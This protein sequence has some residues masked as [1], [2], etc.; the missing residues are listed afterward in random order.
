MN[1][2]LRHFLWTFALILSIFVM[3]GSTVQAEKEK[4][5]KYGDFEYQYIK[6]TEY[7]AIVGY[8]GR[9]EIIIYPDKIEGK[10]VYSIS[11]IS[12]YSCDYLCDEFW[13]VKEV[14][15]PEGVVELEDLNAIRNLEKVQLPKTLEI[16]GIHAFE[17]CTKLESIELPEGLKK[18]ERDAFCDCNSLKEIHIPKGVALI[19]DLAFAGCSGLQKVS[20]SP[21]VKMI[22]VEAF[23]DCTSLREII[24][25]DTV[26][27]IEDGAFWGCKKLTK[28]KLSKN[29]TT[30]NED[31][32]SECNIKTIEIPKKVKKIEAGAFMENAFTSVVIPSKVTY[33]GSNA[34]AYCK[35]LKKVTIKGT[36]LKQMKNRAFANINKKATFDVPNKCKKKYKKMLIKA[37]SF[38][39]GKMK[40]K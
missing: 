2:K 23:V 8:K 21:G 31:T 10:K 32:F 25:P 30:I 3:E 7:V 36:K 37:N 38:K 9:D 15:I 35:K 1:R 14:V 40:I 26:V 29:M 20:I 13:M 24:I 17:G 39:E 33:I 11:N 19:G 27:E 4:I 5:Y 18:I 28:V 16:I 6:D 22:G 34:F 12:H